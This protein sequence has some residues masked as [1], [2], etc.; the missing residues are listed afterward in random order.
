M[1]KQ[2]KRNKKIKEKKKKKKMGKQNYL[3][4]LG[5]QLNPPTPLDNVR[6]KDAVL[7]LPLGS[8]YNIAEKA[9]LHNIVLPIKL[10]CWVCF[11]NNFAINY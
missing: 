2:K 9:S 10:H 3:K 7:W 1:V 5:F 4:T 8:Q 6:K 11:T